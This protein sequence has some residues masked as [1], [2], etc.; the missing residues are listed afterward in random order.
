MTTFQLLTFQTTTNEQG[1]LVKSGAPEVEIMSED[2]LRRVLSERMAPIS[3]WADGFH[4]DD[5]IRVKAGTS[6]WTMG[7]VLEWAPAE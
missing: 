1:R 3:A 2:A 4:A 6:T 5:S 7:R